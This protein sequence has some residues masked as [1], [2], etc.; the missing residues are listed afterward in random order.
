MYNWIDFVV[1]LKLTIVKQLYANKKE[2]QFNS[3]IFQFFLSF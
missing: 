3:I 2:S 1:P